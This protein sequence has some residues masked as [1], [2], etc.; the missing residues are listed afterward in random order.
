MKYSRTALATA[1]ISAAAGVAF[2]PANAEDQERCYGI[3]LAG[4]NDCAAEGSI[5]AG[6]STVDYQG[7]VWTLVDEGACEGIE[8]QTAD[9]RTV[10]GSLQ[11]LDRDLPPEPEA[12]EGETLTLPDN[13]DGQG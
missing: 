4:E 7:D 1:L 12:V 6:T 5:C 2:A 9:G 3:A 10:Y 13:G 11:P 8:N